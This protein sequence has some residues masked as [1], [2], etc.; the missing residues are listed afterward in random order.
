MLISQGIQFSYPEGKPFQFPD[1]TCNER[2]QMLLLG[3]SGTGKTTLLHLLAGLL[4]P[5]GGKL[6]IAGSSMMDLSSAK[7]D[8]FRGEHIGIIFQTAHFIDSLRVEDNLIMPQFLTGRKIDRSKAKDILG[9]LNLAHKAN[10]F[11]SQLSVGEQ[12]RVAI[13]RALI[14]DPKLILADE[15]TSALDDSNARGVIH[16]LKEQAELTGASLIIVTHDQ[17][18]KDEFA[19]SVVL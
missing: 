12:Q 14:N 18:L 5:T 4:R 3:Q 1:F 6:E 9:R 17:R 19:K 13:A 11:T 2:E 7:M 15:P 16:L 8:K 10:S